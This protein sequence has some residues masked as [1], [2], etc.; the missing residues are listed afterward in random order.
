MS[1]CH[2]LEPPLV[3]WDS[4]SAPQWKTWSV[5]A[6][7]ALLYPLHGEGLRYANSTSQ[8]SLA[9]SL[10]RDD[11]GFQVNPLCRHDITSPFP[12]SGNEGYVRNRDVSYSLKITLVLCF[13][14]INKN[15]LLHWSHE[16]VCTKWKALSLVFSNFCTS[17]YVGLICVCEHCGGGCERWRM[18]GALMKGSVN[19]RRRNTH[20]VLSS[21]YTPEQT[22]LLT[23]LEPLPPSLSFCASLSFPQSPFP[24]PQGLTDNSSPPTPLHDTFQSHKISF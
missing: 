9:F 13:W 17:L 16:H 23:F 15:K 6:P 12:P 8:C 2:N 10:Y 1:P 21:H 19:I 4:V 22:H 18:D 5:D 14:F 20:W 11:W 24:I 3:A 7:V